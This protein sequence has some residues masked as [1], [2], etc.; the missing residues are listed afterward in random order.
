M[1]WQLQR[2][3]FVHHGVITLVTCKYYK[4]AAFNANIIP[5]NKFIQMYIIAQKYKTSYKNLYGQ[6]SIY[7]K[8]RII[9]LKIS[10]YKYE[11]LKG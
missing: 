10:I 5:H 9:L 1:A 2:H 7:I 8:N 4:Q 11:S 6:N 3:T